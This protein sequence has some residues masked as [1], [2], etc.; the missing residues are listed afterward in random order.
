M[1]WWLFVNCLKFIL[2]WNEK[3]NWDT[4]ASGW[5]YYRNDFEIIIIIIIIIYVKLGFRFINLYQ[6]KSAEWLERL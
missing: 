3:K 4:G 5:F 6:V 1:C 2:F